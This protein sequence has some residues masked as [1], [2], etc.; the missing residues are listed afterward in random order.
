M[1]AA[2]QGQENV[3]AGS[4]ATPLRDVQQYCWHHCADVS[5]TEVDRVVGEARHGPHPQHIPDTPHAWLNELVG[6]RAAADEAAAEPGG[7]VAALDQA[8]EERKLGR[9]RQKKKKTIID[10]D[11]SASFPPTRPPPPWAAPAAV[12]MARVII[13]PRACTR[14]AHA[15]PRRVPL[16]GASGFLRGASAWAQCP[17][18]GSKA[19][20]VTAPRTWRRSIAGGPEHGMR[21]QVPVAVHDWQRLGCECVH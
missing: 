4:G 20:T 1:A 3:L 2:H 13:A 14:C 15:S 17:W 5:A 8:A 6:A 9:K 16:L 18:R 21:Q 19:S 7:A 12:A 11:A 10:I